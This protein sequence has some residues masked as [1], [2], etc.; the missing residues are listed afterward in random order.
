[1]KSF[2][3][4][5][6]TFAS[7]IKSGVRNTRYGKEIIKK[8]YLMPKLALNEL[9][10]ARITKATISNKHYMSLTSA[11]NTS[12]QKALKVLYRMRRGER[13]KDILKE[14]EIK[15]VD[16]KRHLGNTIYKK[17]GRLL[18]R[19]TDTIERNMV[20]YENGRIRSIIIT[21][22]RD[23]RRIAQYM[24]AVKEAL[25]TGD[26]KPLRKFKNMVTTD[27]YGN[28]RK[29]ETELEKLYEIEEQKEDSEF[30]EVYRW[31]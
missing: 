20:F 1:M 17:R 2:S 28:K 7:W 24:N 29:F 5:Y 22:S 6:G 19:P 4:K 11:E 18:A 16:V 25:N 23:A 15:A 9:R 13:F 3:S 26:D 8:H 30:F 31:D 21:N 27:A 14:I 12:R 10:N